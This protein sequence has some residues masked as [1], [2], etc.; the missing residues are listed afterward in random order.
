MHQ[1]F[2][3]PRTLG[4]TSSMSLT[5]SKLGVDMLALMAYFCIPL[6]PPKK[7]EAKEKI[8]EYSMFVMLV[9]PC[10]CTIEAT[11]HHG[12]NETL[13][14]FCREQNLIR[15]WLW[16]AC[17][18]TGCSAPK[19]AFLRSPKVRLF[20]LRRWVEGQCFWWKKIV[21]SQADWTLIMKSMND[22]ASYCI[23]CSYS[24]EVSQVM[25]VPPVIILI[26][27]NF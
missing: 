10:I 15:A 16:K 20:R 9:F 6:Y 26:S 21:G 24:M 5:R 18:K 23:K 12:G 13:D 19:F 11:K 14:D 17:W 2:K 22:H 25:G 7:V 4:T 27:I 1:L 8:H 3:M